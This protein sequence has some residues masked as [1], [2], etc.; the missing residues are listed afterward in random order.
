LQKAVVLLNSVFE[1]LKV[2]FYLLIPGI[3][4]DNVHIC[5]NSLFLTEDT[6]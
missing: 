1:F 6:P 3:C 2:Y 5:K 4:S